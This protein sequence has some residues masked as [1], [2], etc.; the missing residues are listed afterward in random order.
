MRDITLCHPKLQTLAVK[1]VE[2]CAKQGLQIKIGGTRIQSKSM[3]PTVPATGII[4]RKTGTCRGR[5]GTVGRMGRWR[6]GILKYI[7]AYVIMPLGKRIKCSIRTTSKNPK[8]SR[9]LGFLFRFCIQTPPFCTSL[10]G[11]N[12]SIISCSFSFFYGVWFNYC[13]KSLLFIR[14]IHSR[15]DQPL[16]RC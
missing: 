10:G 8:E 12:I 14:H 2:E 16:S 7:F 3:R 4:S 6:F 9:S 15:M 5:A 1:P 11:G 13:K